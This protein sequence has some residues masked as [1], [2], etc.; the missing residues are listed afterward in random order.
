[1]IDFGVLIYTFFFSAT[2]KYT[3]IRKESLNLILSLTKKL[4]ETQNVEQF[5]LIVSVVKDL[6]PDL[7]K[8]NQPEIRS[9]VVDI[10]NM[11]QI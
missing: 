3:V 10:K 11:L 5:N 8:D 6:L 7:T 4:K 1:M 2:S 9:R